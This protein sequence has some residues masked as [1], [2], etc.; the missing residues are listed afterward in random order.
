MQSLSYKITTVGTFN[1]RLIQCVSYLYIT[2][3]SSVLDVIF[4]NGEL[5]LIK[6]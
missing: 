3:G 6:F 2:E 5:L 1:C 4:L